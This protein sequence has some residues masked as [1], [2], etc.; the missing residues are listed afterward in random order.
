MSLVRVPISF[1]HTVKAL[2]PIFTLLI[3]RIIYK[4]HYSIDLYVSLFP[5]F[6][7]VIVASYSELH[8][9]LAGLVSALV[10]TLTFSIQNL[11]SKKVLANHGHPLALLLV[12]TRAAL[13]MILPIWLY[14]DGRSLFLDNNAWKDNFSGDDISAEMKQTILYQ[15]IFNGVFSVAQ[16]ITAFAFLSIVSAV[17]YSVAN[18]AKRVVIIISSII[19]FNNPISQGNVYGMLLCLAGIIMYNIVKFQ[20]KH[21]KFQDKESELISIL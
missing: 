13:V 14:F 21:S 1:T 12:S 10:A 7:G 2:T 8:F 18:V 6:L 20:E 17:T 5:I 9:D 16:S 3:S 19:I 4:E 15:I 11:F